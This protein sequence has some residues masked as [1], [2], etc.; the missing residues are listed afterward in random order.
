MKTLLFLVYSDAPISLFFTEVELT[1]NVTSVQ[2]CNTVHG[3]LYMLCCAHY[4]CRY[5][6]SRFHII[7]ISWTIYPI[8]YLSF[9]GFDIPKLKA[10][11]GFPFMHF[12]SLPIPLL[13]TTS[14]LCSWVCFYLLL[15]HLCCSLDSTCK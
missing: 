4:T 7:I 8:L 12:A 1:C 5:R 9:H 3:R 14:S 15:A 6:L 10:C 11:I 13:L 2:V